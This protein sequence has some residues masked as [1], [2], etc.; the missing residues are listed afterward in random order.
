M[1]CLSI[2]SACTV[3]TAQSVI[4][5][6]NIRFTGV[7]DYSQAELLSFA[8][9]TPGA[10]VPLAD[11][12]SA[13]Q[14]FNDTGLFSDVRFASNSTGLVFTLKPMPADNLLP[15]RFPNLVWWSNEEL[16]QA[17]K[18]RVPLYRGA[19]PISGNIQ[20]SVSA[21]LTAMLAE[22]NVKAKITALPGGAP[23]GATPTLI[24][25]VMETPEVRV[26]SITFTSA[27]PAMQPKLDAITK[28]LSGQPFD[29]Y[30]TDS[31]ISSRVTTA[32]RNEG[33]LDAAILSVTRS[34]P[35]ISPD[36]INIDLTATVS[37]GQPYHLSALTWAGSDVISTADFDK[38]SR[39]HPE[40]IASQALLRE[41]LAV[42][43][44][45][46]YA[47]GFQDAKVQAPATLDRAIHHVS[48]KINVIPGEQY[49]LHS[50]KVEGVNDQQRKDFDSAWHM[51]PG[52]FYDVNYLTTFLNKNTA[53]RS[54][55]GY[56]ATYKA[57]SDPNSHLVDLV[58]TFVKGGTLVRVN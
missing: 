21:A 31:G 28:D 13:A 30:T 54:F 29:Q 5:P 17:L 2:S 3:L 36:A 50:V 14:R 7:P 51:N 15:A 9:L 34:T 48:Y 39:L 22:K 38:R 57:F 11:I 45:A 18:T 47:K 40:D 25:F 27:S 46:Y 16:A 26:H 37:E 12:Q 44:R 43:A 41:S 42:I 10:I 23:A 52:D 53:L 4:L 33:Y 24:S 8:Q 1:F 58:I 56:S 32:Y 55:N 19:V 20:D 49:R 6:K 35:H